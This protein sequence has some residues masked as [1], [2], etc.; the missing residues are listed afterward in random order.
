M[1]IVIDSTELT[2]T[3]GIILRQKRKVG[4]TMWVV[5]VGIRTKLINAHF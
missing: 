5:T 2:P 1:S 4:L 3:T